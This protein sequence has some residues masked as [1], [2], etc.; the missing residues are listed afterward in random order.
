MTNGP[1]EKELG[2]KEV[3]YLREAIVQHTGKSPGAT[4]FCG[5][6]PINGISISSDLDISN[7][8]MMPF[9]YR[10]GDHLPLKS[11]I[12]IDTIKIVRLVGQ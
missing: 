10:V 5:S 11:L 1:L 9:G 7:A 2:D 6:K 3:L 8:C 12:G 4:F